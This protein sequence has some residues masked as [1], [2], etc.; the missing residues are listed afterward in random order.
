M[1]LSSI[2]R[3]VNRL[4]KTFLRTPMVRSHLRMAS[5][6]AQHLQALVGAGAPMEHL[7]VS[8]DRAA[9]GFHKGAESG[10]RRALESTQEIRQMSA[11]V[12]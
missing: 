11:A 3:F 2:P 10:A 9:S 8:P 7:H 1:D 5:Q 12:G 6:A 4:T